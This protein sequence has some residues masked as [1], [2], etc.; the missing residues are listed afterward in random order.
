ME[1][2]NINVPSYY[3]DA[4]L[5]SGSVLE[6][7]GNVST[8]LG[9]ARLGSPTNGPQLFFSFLLRLV[10]IGLRLGAVRDVLTSPWL[11][12]MYRTLTFCPTT[13]VLT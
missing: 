2:Q 5:L 11:N 4:K 3:G 13:S 10:G 7:I 8:W 12:A 9:L 6:A 1:A